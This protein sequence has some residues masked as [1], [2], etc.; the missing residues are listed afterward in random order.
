MFP[1]AAAADLPEAPSAADAR[2]LRDAELAARQNP[3]DAGLALQAGTLAGN[4]GR[5]R[6]ALEWFR[7]AAAL[8]P[9]LLPA[10]TGQGQM[11]MALGRPGLAATAYE[12]ALKL[13]P[14]EPQLLLELARAYT[15]LRAFPEA[16]RYAGLAE[17]R[18]PTNP[19]VY[20]ALANIYAETMSVDLSLK[21]A[22]RAC[23]LGPSDPENWSTQ[24]ALLL[25]LH[26]YPEAEKALQ[27]ALDLNPAH[28][29]ANI[30]KARTLIEGPK[31]AGADRQAF[32]V[33]ARVRTVEPANAEALLLQGQIAVRA[34]QPDLAII[35]LRQARE[36]SPRDPEPALALGQALIR[37]G[38]GEEG[39]RVVSQAQK[40]GPRGVAFLDLEELARKNPDPAIAERL[41]DLYRRKNLVDP[42]IRVLERA[43]KRT[44]EN[45]RLRRKLAEVRREAAEE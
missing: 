43:R 7:R 11:W 17:K 4:Q 41:A 31:T 8:D 36:V 33:L 21:N 1:A 18:A 27:R 37:S 19:E 15:Y 45:A 24:G 42:A 34:G 40:L 30:L 9:Q 38:K 39:V 44:P 6:A 26:R 3:R 22:A 29:T 32:A 2:E 14:D 28:V 12:Q 16:V 5:H 35:L 10:R 25:R 20:R 23:E 13:A